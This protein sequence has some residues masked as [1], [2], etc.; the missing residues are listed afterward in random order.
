[1]RGR[2]G[3]S[4]NR[5]SPNPLTRS[6]ESNG[7][8][9]KI[10]DSAQQIARKVHHSHGTQSAGDVSWPRTTCTRRY[11]RIIMAAMAQMP[12]QPVRDIRDDEDADD[13]MDDGFTPVQPQQQAAPAGSRITIGISSATS[14]VVTAMAMVPSSRVTAASRSQSS[15]HACEVA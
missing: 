10:T 5:K 9:V 6:Y 2:G 15:R 12:Q 4:N 8:D 3:G 14:V 13:R 1:M 7:P 11:N